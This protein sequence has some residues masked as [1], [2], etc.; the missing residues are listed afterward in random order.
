MPLEILDLPLRGGHTDVYGIPS[1]SEPIQE[2]PDHEGPI[3]GSE[4]VYSIFKVLSHGSSKFVSFCEWHSVLRP[5]PNA[6]PLLDMARYGIGKQIVVLKSQVV[7]SRHDWKKMK[8]LEVLRLLPP[9]R[10]VVALYDYFFTL[11]TRQLHLVLGAME[12]NLYHL[13]RTRRGRPF[14]GGLVSSILYQIAL[15]LHHVHSYNYFHRN[16]CPESILV[17]TMGLF[18]YPVIPSPPDTITPPDAPKEKDVTVI[19]KLAEFDSV[20]ER[21]DEPVAT[22]ITTYRWYRA[23]ELVLLDHNYSSPVDV[24]AFGAIIGEILNLQPLFPGSDELDQM[25]K[26]CEVLGSPSDVT[27][28]DRNGQPVDGGPWPAGHVLA[29]ELGFVFPQIV[30]G[31]L[32]SLFNPSIPSSL[33]ALMQKLLMYDSQS[34]LTSQGCLEHAYFR[35]TAP[36]RHIPTSAT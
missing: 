13:I 35:N 8:E 16:L 17:T 3:P 19:I 24:W 22:H 14:A 20:I 7:G 33:V 10:N 28:V 29:R 1:L 26:I 18:D 30:V 2:L 15:G 32:S 12:G 5:A 11:N 36:Y 31:P 23:P 6:T 4:R 21:N 27:R 25:F 9:H 34:R